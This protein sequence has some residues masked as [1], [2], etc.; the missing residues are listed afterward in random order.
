MTLWSI[1]ATFE[2][3][4]GSELIASGFDSAPDEGFQTMILEE[5]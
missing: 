5:T 4:S 1:S 2:K 3:W